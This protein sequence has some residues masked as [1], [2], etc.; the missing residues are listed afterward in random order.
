MPGGSV[1]G[2]PWY[3]TAR[4]TIKG[5]VVIAFMFIVAVITVFGLLAAAYGTETR[6]DFAR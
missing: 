6:D 1:Q 5:N 3:R 4:P 2:E